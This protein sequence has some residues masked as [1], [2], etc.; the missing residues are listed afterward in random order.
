MRNKKITYIIITVILSLT[1]LYVF[2]QILMVNYIVK[3]SLKLILLL[4]FP[5]LYS[6]KYNDP[7]IKKTFEKPLLSYP[8]N[9]LWLSGIVFVSIILAFI[10][11]QGQL[12]LVTIIS[13][14]E[15]KYKIHAR[16]FIFYGL[17]I[18]FINSFIEEFFFRGFIFL[19]LKNLGLRKWGYL[20]SS[21]AFALYH[22]AIFKN[23]FSPMV[24][25]LALVGLIFGGM[26]FNFLDEK[27]NSFFNSWLVHI[28]ADLAII[29]IGF[30]LFS[31]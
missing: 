10:L 19:N 15:N 14:L 18:T 3:T 25:M 16:N 4:L 29:L 13:E 27:P 31:L 11:L 26:I 24:F 2:D 22:I 28:S 23:W 8:K 20:I 5:L 7:W 9:S 6:Y 30:Y 12:D 21:V 17:Y 1:L